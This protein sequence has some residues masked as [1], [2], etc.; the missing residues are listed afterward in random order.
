M[1]VIESNQVASS[2]ENTSCGI[3]FDAQKEVAFGEQ[4]NVIPG[5]AMANGIRTALKPAPIAK[6]ASRLRLSTICNIA[7]GKV[8]CV[9]IS[10]CRLS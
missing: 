6:L 1:Q 3:L 7:N 9:L 8:V 5:Q 4:T 2:N 10:S